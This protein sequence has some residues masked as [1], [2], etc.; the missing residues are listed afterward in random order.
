MNKHVQPKIEDRF[1][2]E[3]RENM[4]Y[5]EL[6]YNNVALDQVNFKDGATRYE[7][8]YDLDQ[9]KDVMF[10]SYNEAKEYFDTI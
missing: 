6:D 5:K 3:S 1:I 10:D 8:C 9:G 2:E 4:H 7:I